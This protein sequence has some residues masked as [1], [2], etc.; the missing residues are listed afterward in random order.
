MGR[1]FTWKE[2]LEHRIPELSHF[3]LVV[4]ELKKTIEQE[5]GIIG[6]VLCGSVL[7][8]SF[9]ERSDIDCVL[10]YDHAK[11]KHVME[12]LKTVVSLSNK[13][14]IPLQLIPVDADAAEQQRHNISLG[15]GWHL[16]RASQSGGV[17]K[18]NIVHRLKMNLN[19][20]HQE[21]SDYLGHKLARMTK[22]L[23]KMRSMGWYELHQFLQKVLEAPMHI[24]RK[25]MQ[26]NP[27]IRD[28]PAKEVMR[29]YL[30]TAQNQKST[31][32]IG[33]TGLDGEYT[34]VLKAQI[35]RPNGG[36]Y[37]DIIERIKAAAWD[38]HEF[39]RLNAM[40]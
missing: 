30:R 1:V 40:H 19:S 27:N 6:G 10:V 2:V 26:T 39:I 36:Q 23:V 18:E 21:V 5:S 4:A 24:A 17:I 14:H 34:T 35:Q 8:N 13:L 22:G 37:G 25:L 20:Q 38:V 15:F 9:T 29:H 16:M 11:F 32:F 28:L 12:S 3:P 33:L 31:L 7:D